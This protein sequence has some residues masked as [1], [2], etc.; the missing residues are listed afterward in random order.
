[1]LVKCKY[2]NDQSP[3]C[4]YCNDM[5]GHFT[6]DIYK[7]LREI[8]EQSKSFSIQ[9]INNDYSERELLFLQNERR[10]IDRISIDISK[11]TRRISK[12]N[13]KAQIYKR[14]LFWENLNSKP[15]ALPAI[16]EILIEYKIL[17]DTLKWNPFTNKS[18]SQTTRK[19]L[20]KKGSVE[21]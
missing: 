16:Y 11:A 3:T 21:K 12:S 19:A 10:L 5:G 18:A 15:H 9:S 7:S 4:L 20:R 17:V 13:I 6:E 1:M 2:C 8:S 14:V